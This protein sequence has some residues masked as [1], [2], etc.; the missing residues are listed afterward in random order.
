MLS[1][2]LLLSAVASFHPA[3][4][5]GPAAKDGVL[6]VTP[7]DSLAQIGQ[8]LAQDASIREVVLQAGTYPGDWTIPRLEKEDATPHPLLIRAADGAEVIFDGAKPLSKPKA[9]PGRPGVFSVPSEGGYK[10]EPEKL[11]EPEARVRYLLA[12]DLDAVQRFP[13][14]YVVFGGTLCFHTSD[15]KPPRGDRVLIGAKDFGI[16]V[17]RPDVTVRGL[18][19]RNFTARGKWSVAVSLAAER[20]T[21]ERCD[22]TNASFGFKLLSDDD[23]IVDSTARDVGGGVYMAGRRGRVER[24]RFLKTRDDFAVPT[25]PQDDTG[26]E[27]YSPADTGTI[28]GNLA[29]GFAQGI[30]IKADE[31]P[32]VVEGN[33]L[34]AA[35]QQQGFIATRWHPESVFRRNV[36]SGYEV[37]MTFGSARTGTRVEGN[38]DEPKFVD[39]GAGDYRL[40]SDSPCLTKAGEDKTPGQGEATDG[41]E[42]GAGAVARSPERIDLRAGPH[43]DEA[44]QGAAKHAAAAAEARGGADRAPRAWHVSPAG[45]DDATGET[46]SPLLSIQDAVDRAGPGDTILLE[47]GVYIEPVRFDHGG[48]EGRPITLR[49]AERWKA[50]LDG[51]RRHDELIRIEKAPFVVI[52]DLEIRWYREAGIRVRG[53]ADARV[54][55][56]RIWN[57]PWA[58]TWPVGSGVQV[59]NSP[60]FTAT[61]NVVY[62]Q[63][64]GFYLISSP[65]ATLTHNTALANL[66]GGAV[67]IRSIDGTTCTNNSFAYQA[68]DAISIVED[69]DGKER[70]GRFTC[71]YNNYGATLQPG[72]PGEKALE[73]R[74][75]DR[76]LFTQSKAIVYFEQKPPPFQRFR[77]MA[78]WREFSGLDAHSI[79]ADPLFVDSAAGDFRLEAGSPNRGAGSD[80]STIG[81]LAD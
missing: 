23:A 40:A 74:P 65:G 33:T 30:F 41:K 36:V 71:D 21:V 26:I 22:A 81:A 44:K 10:G 61:G 48:V 53:S 76:Q 51:R 80:G 77:T 52:E 67:F 69:Q 62:R 32:W 75:K 25:Y 6:T 43:D 38:C 15:G 63:E 47:A 1:T 13:A 60:R 72:E 73:P 45:R 4:K 59:E 55:G 70:L 3:A 68:N 19:F 34:V 66:Y 8:R 39:A 28:R 58:G 24:C 7:G 20:V 57:A 18:R 5:Q 27:A 49:A 37:P 2:I 56:C 35:E 17:R 79:F 29:I 46:G 16:E 31:T 11:W 12:A 64:R 42:I 78:A 54:Q 9:V 50:I 14:S